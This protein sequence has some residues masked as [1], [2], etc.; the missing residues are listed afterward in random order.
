[1]ESL[2]TDHCNAYAAR[3]SPFGFG[4]PFLPPGMGIPSP[5]MSFDFAAAVAA[6]GD[7]TMAAILR[8]RAMLFGLSGGPGGG[9]PSFGARLPPNMCGPA[10]GSPFAPPGAPGS[11]SSSSFWPSSKSPSEAGMNHEQQ[12]Y[13]QM[14]QMHHQQQQQ[15]QAQQAQ[16]QA[17]YQALAASGGRLP[18]GPA[19]GGPMMGG[20]QQAAANSQQAA[21]AAQLAALNPQLFAAMAVYTSGNGAAGALAAPA[22]A[23][24]PN[25]AKMLSP[26]FLKT[27]QLEGHS[28]EGGKGV[29]SAGSSPPR[30]EGME[31]KSV[32]GNT[33][34]V[35]TES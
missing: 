1:M 9:P 30:K 10:G 23:N 34:A 35:A 13:Q 2:M 8:E 28:P 20:G 16:Q 25:A 22:G 15:Q 14:Q 24:N 17:W 32:T 27:M 29:P 3:G 18:V 33:T 11:Q 12:M 31:T 26:T 19:A 6:Q 7:P 5:H 21:F 4:P